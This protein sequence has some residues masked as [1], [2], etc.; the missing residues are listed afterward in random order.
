MGGYGSGWHRGSRRTVDS[1]LGFDFGWMVRQCPITAGKWRK[2]IQWSY[3][4]QVSGSCGITIERDDAKVVA[5]RISCTRDGEE[6]EQEFE[7]S[8]LPM[9]RGGWKILAVCPYC[10]KRRS[11]LYFSRLSLVCCRGCAHLTYHSSQSRTRYSGFWHTFDS[12]L[13]EERREERKWESR[14]RGNQRAKEWRERMS[15]NRT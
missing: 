5:I 9:P 13:R 11:K 6:F 2:S 12:L 4:G 8:H 3:G 14:E 10:H 1:S 15:V 7:I